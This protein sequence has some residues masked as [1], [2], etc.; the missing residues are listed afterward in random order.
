MRILLTGSSGRVGRA[1]Y[2]AL[3]GDHEIIGVD[4]SVFSTT[5]IVG[6]CG[7]QGVIKPALEGVD[8]WECR[9]A[10]D[11]ATGS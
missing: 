10:L 3:A 9:V 11:L 8:A 7:D 5:R 6:D 4:H 2:G 1:I